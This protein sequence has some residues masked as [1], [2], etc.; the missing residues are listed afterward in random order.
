M[1][2]VF[3]QKQPLKGLRH[4]Q[5]RLNWCTANR[6]GHSEIK[7][8]VYHPQ[9]KSCFPVV[10][11]FSNGIRLAKTRGKAGSGKWLG[12]T[13]VTCEAKKTIP[14][15]IK[16]FKS[17]VLPAAQLRS[18]C[19]T[20]L[21]AVQDIYW[22]GTYWPNTW[23]SWRITW[24]EKCPCNPGSFTSSFLQ[25]KNPVLATFI[26]QADTYGQWQMYVET[27]VCAPP[28]ALLSGHGC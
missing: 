7:Y 18:N 21:Q 19:F 2:P 25:P 14:S 28:S 9:I 24:E 26:A 15:P 12:V 1:E 11:C 3:S 13:F 5:H 8:L 17:A 16:V 23:Y 20:M 6:V 27:D 4:C 10:R 22:D